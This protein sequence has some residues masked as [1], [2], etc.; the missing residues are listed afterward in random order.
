MPTDLGLLRGSFVNAK[1]KE[2]LENIS[3]TPIETRGIPVTS[4][5]SCLRHHVHNYFWPCWKTT[6]NIKL[7]FA[8]NR[9]TIIF[10]VLHSHYVDRQSIRSA[11][12]TNKQLIDR[13]SV[14]SSKKSKS[15]WVTSI[16]I[17]N[18]HLWSMLLVTICMCRS[19]PCFLKVL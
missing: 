7:T 17:R 9:V 4:R 19:L 13:Q 6:T 12:K 3:W 16:P 18:S 5:S 2:M 11:Q 10:F 14:C 15:I 1:N 8:I